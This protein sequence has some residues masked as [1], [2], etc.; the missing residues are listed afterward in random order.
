MIL[1]TQIIHTQKITH[2]N[3]TVQYLRVQGCGTAAGTQ[4]LASREQARRV[5][6]R[7][8]GR[9]RE[10]VELKGLR[11]RRDGGRAAISLTPDMMA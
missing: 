9:G 3:L 8:G 6:D 2:L 4:E 7:T 10:A 5:T 1:F 11:D